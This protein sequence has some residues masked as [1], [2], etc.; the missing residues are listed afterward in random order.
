MVT[1]D[2]TR[3]AYLVS[4][5]ARICREFVT[6]GRKVL[7]Q[8]PHSD[9]AGARFSYDETSSTRQ[10]YLSSN[11][12]CGGVLLSDAVDYFGYRRLC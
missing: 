8:R 3:E 2:V 11:I 7:T 4:Y 9:T 10:S 5:G 12:L 6:L 1:L